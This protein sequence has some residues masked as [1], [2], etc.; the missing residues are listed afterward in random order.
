[1]R[2]PG[3]LDHGLLLSAHCDATSEKQRDLFAALLKIRADLFSILASF[4]VTPEAAEDILQD[5]MIVTLRKR[6]DIRNYRAYL[7]TLVFKGCL[8][9]KRSLSTQR[10]REC[11][12][13]G[14]ELIEPF[15]TPQESV[16]AR[17]EIERLLAPLPAN[18]RQVLCLGAHG[19]ERAEIASRLGVSENSIS[20]LRSR[21]FSRMKRK[22]WRRH[23]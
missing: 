14:L 10:E 4:R 9:Y 18:Q 20:Q 1:L 11:T 19:F 7:C 8:R 16:E 2:T 22:L 15:E 23:G 12:W 6:E 21:G 17:I 3:L 5:A 13:P